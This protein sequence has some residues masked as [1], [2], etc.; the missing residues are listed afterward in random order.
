MLPIV[1]VVHD[2]CDKIE[3][4]GVS[5]P[6]QSRTSNEDRAFLRDVNITNNNNRKVLSYIPFLIV[7]YKAK[8]VDT[9]PAYTGG[10]LLSTN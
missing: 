5:G 7:C 4:G 9:H 2:A 3:A 8:L 6:L 10:A 1:I